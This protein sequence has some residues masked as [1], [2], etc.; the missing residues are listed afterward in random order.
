MDA[1][2][3]TLL[4]IA[5][6]SVIW[7]LALFLIHLNK[8]CKDEMF[9]DSKNSIILY[10]NYLPSI[11]YALTSISFICWC[12]TIQSID[13][14]ISSSSVP[15]IILISTILLSSF[16]QNIIGF[17]RY[18][19]TFHGSHYAPSK[20]S[21]YPIFFLV[22]AVFIISIIMLAIL[23]FNS[24][25][26]IF[27][28]IL[29][30]VSDALFSFTLTARMVIALLQLFRV[31]DSGATGGNK[32]VEIAIRM[33]I[34]N[35]FSFVITQSIFI[36]FI[37]YA[38]IGFTKD[39]PQNLKQ[40]FDYIVFMV[41]FPIY[42][43]I[44]PFLRLMIFKQNH[45]YYHKLCSRLHKICTVYFQRNIENY[46]RS[47]KVKEMPTTTTSTHLI[48]ISKH[49]DRLIVDGFIRECQQLLT[50]NN[51][52]YTIAIQAIVFDYYHQSV[53]DSFISPVINPSNNASTPQK[54]QH[55]IELQAE[56]PNEESDK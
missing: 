54:L 5:A 45:V 27:G 42:I 32:I 38:T 41:I 6:L 11:S 13:D 23:G 17:Y 52:N 4:V 51:M 29:L 36:S 19:R 44:L 37:I 28:C 47:V 34:I 49:N 10:L 56:G 24:E 20:K 3:I 7:I 15:M 55:A 30:V 35:G 48:A 9:K 40:I 46:E 25:N 14:P 22:S 53:T 12:F 39:Y 8:T 16:L 31:L 50:D 21:L 26:I 43:F 33:L 18:Y 1:T 2:A